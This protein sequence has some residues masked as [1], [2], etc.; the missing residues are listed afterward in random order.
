MS[1]EVATIII[2]HDTLIWLIG[3][4][5][6]GYGGLILMGAKLIAHN[7]NK[8]IESIY[9]TITNCNEQLTGKIN[10]SE[11]RINNLEREVFGKRNG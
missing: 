4:T 5:V 7:F 11:S 8:S 6:A 9:L 1:A 10:V 3:A 2:D